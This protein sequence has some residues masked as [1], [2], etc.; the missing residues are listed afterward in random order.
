MSVPIATAAEKR[1]RQLATRWKADSQFMSSATEMSML[2][3][4]QEIIEMG[5]AALPLI[6]SD[7]EEE[8]NHWFWALQA[9]TGEDPIS[10]EHTGDVD[11]MA[12]D[13]LIWGREHGYI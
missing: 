3:P 1:F 8:P 13:W 5:E 11:A 9:I 4:Y 2:Q 10:S 6:F 12:E 7:L